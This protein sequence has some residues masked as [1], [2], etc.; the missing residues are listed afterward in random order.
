MPQLACINHQKSVFIT[1]S[2]CIYNI[3]RIYKKNSKSLLG[4]SH[5]R[6][7]LHTQCENTIHPVYF[8]YYFTYN[9]TIPNKQNNSNLLSDMLPGPNF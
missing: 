9:F 6:K 2:Q 1:G 8:F 4:T 3:C 5:K 7:Y